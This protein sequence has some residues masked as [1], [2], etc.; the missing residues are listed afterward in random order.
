[1]IDLEMAYVPIIGCTA[2]DDRET[3]DLCIEVGMLHVV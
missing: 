3:L 2:H 1:M